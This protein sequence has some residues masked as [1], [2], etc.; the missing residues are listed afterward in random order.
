MIPITEDFIETISQQAKTSTWKRKNYNYHTDYADPFQRLLNAME[1]FS[2]VQPHK[3]ED[4]DKREVFI[5]LKGRAVVIEFDDN[6][7]I[8]QHFILCQSLG[9]YAV[10]IPARVWHTIIPLD[11][12]TVI[13]EVKDGPYNPIDDKNFATWAPKENTRGT[14]DFIK[15]IL[16]ELRINST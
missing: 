1:P 11:E 4:L 2:Y 10:E 3:H 7:G 9:N 15:K 5:I 14:I 6:G 16:S 8:I 12:G 13:Y